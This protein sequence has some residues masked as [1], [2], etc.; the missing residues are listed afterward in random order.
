MKDWQI[1]LTEKSAGTLRRLLIEK[2][3]IG[4]SNTSCR[5]AFF[6]VYVCYLTKCTLKQNLIHSSQM[7]LITSLKATTCL[8]LSLNWRIKDSTTKRIHLTF[9]PPTSNF[10]SL[11]QRNSSIIHSANPTHSCF[12]SGPFFSPGFVSYSM[13]LIHSL[14]T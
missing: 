11:L 14:D 8:K 9:S 10:Y 13:R 3:R 2:S 4:V 6:K 12:L 1:I 5:N 7:R